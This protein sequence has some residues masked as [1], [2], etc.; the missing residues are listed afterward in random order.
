MAT[1]SY[2]TLFGTNGAGQTGSQEGISTL[3]GQQPRPRQTQDQ[4]QPAQ[5]FAQLQQRGMARPAPQAP[6][7]QPFQRFG[8]SEQAQQARSGMLTQLQQQLA[9]PTRFDTQAFQ[10]IRGA[11]AANLQAEYGAE[12]QR[13]NE[14]LARRGLSASSVG[15]GRM[16]DLAGQQARALASLDAQLLQQAAQTQAQD[17]LAAMQ[18]AGQFAE[19][20]GAQDLAQFE[21]N[22]VAQAAE[23]QQALQGAQFGQQQ[24]EF[25]RGQ[26]LAAAQAQQQGGLQ[27]M[28]LALRRQLGLGEL[29]LSERRQTAQETQFGQSLAEQ[30]AAREQQAGLSGRELDLRAQQLQQEEAL[31]GRSLSI[32]EARL[33]AQQEQFTKTQ[34]QQAAQFEATLSAED[35]RFASTLKEQQAARLQQLGISDKQLDLEAQRLKQQAELEGRSLSLQEARDTAEVDYRAKSLQQQAEL[36]GRRLTNEEAR[37]QADTEFRADQLKQQGEQFTATLGA[38]E[39]R[40]VRT[41]KEQQEARLQQLGISNK[42]FDADAARLKQEAELQGRSL[43]LQEARDLAE[44][45]YRAKQL[46]QQATLEGNRITAEEAR[47]TAQ[48]DFQRD[49]MT[50][51]EAL[52]KDGIAVDRERLKAQELQFKDDLQLRKDSLAS[53]EKEADLERKLR[54]RLGMAELTGSVEINGQKVSTMAAQRLGQEGAQIA[55]QQAAQMTQATGT[56]YRVNAQG[57]VVPMTDADGKP[58]RSESSLARLSQEELARAELTGTLRVNGVDIS[59][60]AAKQLDQARLNQLA[61]QAAQQSQLTGMMYKVDERGQIVQELGT[62]GQPISTEARRAQ[63]QQEEQARLDRQLRQQLGLG[64]LTGQVTIG[65]GADARTQAT[66]GAQQFGL[67]AQQQF[68]AQRQAAQ[69]MLVQLAAGLAQSTNIPAA[70]LTTLITDLQN[71]LLNPTAQQQQQQGMDFN[72]QEFQDFLTRLSQQFGARG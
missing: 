10:Q 55:A 69:Q 24:T 23:F 67:S 43:S 12:Q 4:Q 60:L 62:N 9:Q 66:L 61:Q 64:E 34:E 25:E 35:K 21:A 29:G 44:V 17:R 20:A 48:L 56:V 41:I 6:Q 53:Q 40:F 22:R 31:Q 70:T 37:T 14:E 42:Q 16:G 63:I 45:D 54:E 46:E 50:V 8:G 11:Q 26:A 7:G 72:S 33:A 3:F 39:Q 47:Q 32:E 36:E 15:G 57:Q 38:E 1:S 27:G 71:R 49:Q 68:F 5:T 2:S 19:L 18:A 30:R 65:E 51:E 13:L 58:V 52:R 28:E 59:T